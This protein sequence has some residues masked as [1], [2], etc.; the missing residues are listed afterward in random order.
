[1]YIIQLHVTC[2]SSSSSSPS[3]T[4]SHT[5]MYIYNQNTHEYHQTT[6]PPLGAHRLSDLVSSLEQ[7]CFLAWAT[8]LSSLERPCFLCLSDINYIKERIYAISLLLE[9]PFITWATTLLSY[10]SSITL[11]L[12]WGA[13]FNPTSFKHIIHH[14]YLNVWETTLSLECWI[15]SHRGERIFTISFALK[16]QVIP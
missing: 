3:H 12:E 16:L 10:C 14:Y 7:S 1:M 2:I 11:K 15:G 5:Y 6:I 9:H 4:H 8:L 13:L